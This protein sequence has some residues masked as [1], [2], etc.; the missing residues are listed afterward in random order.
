MHAAIWFHFNLWKPVVQIP[1]VGF[2][3]VAGWIGYVGREYLNIVKGE[4]KPEEKEIIIDVP[5]AL[6]LAGKG[7]GWPFRVVTELRE[8]TLTEKAENITVSPR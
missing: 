5:L 4:K 7:A 8:G 2:L 6:S 3:Y 1:P